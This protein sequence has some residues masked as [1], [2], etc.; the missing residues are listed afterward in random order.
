LGKTR[1]AFEVFKDDDFLKELVVYVDASIVIN[2]A[3][4]VVDWVSIGLKGVSLSI[5]VIL[6]F[7]GTY[8]KKF[9]EQIA[10]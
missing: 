3:S 5:I 2:I 9:A 1:T 8:K 10:N 4:L 6:K 7:M